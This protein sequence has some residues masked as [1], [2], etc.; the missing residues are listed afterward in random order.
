MIV[1]EREQFA[2]EFEVVTPIDQRW[3]YGRFC[4][5]AQNQMVGDKVD[6][7]V[8]LRGCLNWLRDFIEVE[9]DRFEPLL[10][11][12]SA[13]DIFHRLSTEIYYDSRSTVTSDTRFNI[14][15]LG[16]TAFDRTNLFLVENEQGD[17]RLI[18]RAL[19]NE[20][21]SALVHRGIMRSVI[22]EAIGV[23]EVAIE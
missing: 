3:V 2:V 4:F 5:W 18:W 11:D 7:S 23:L 21:Q 15:H 22:L 14:S 9:Q 10:F 13:D 1:G 6:D 12:Q 17:G 20:I 16:M 8:D 19:K